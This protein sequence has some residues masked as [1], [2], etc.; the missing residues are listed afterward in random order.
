YDFRRLYAGVAD[1]LGL[2]GPYEGWRRYNTSQG[3]YRV[4]YDVG[5]PLLKTQEWNYLTDNARV[6]QPDGTSLF[7]HEAIRD[8]WLWFRPEAGPGFGG[9]RRKLGNTYITQRMG[10]GEVTTHVSGGNGD[11]DIIGNGRVPCLNLRDCGLTMD[12]FDSG[13]FEIN[14]PYVITMDPRCTSCGPYMFDVKGTQ[15]GG[16]LVAEWSPST[17][18]FSNL[19]GAAT[20]GVTTR[21]EVFDLLKSSVAMGVSAE[22]KVSHFWAFG[23]IDAGGFAAAELW[24]GERTSAMK[25]DGTPAEQFNLMKIGVADDRRQTGIADDPTK[26]GIADGDAWPAARFGA[27]L[28]VRG[29]VRNGKHVKDV[30]I[31]FANGDQLAPPETKLPDGRGPDGLL[32]VGGDSG[33]G[34][35][36]DIWTFDGAWRLAGRLPGVDGGLADAGGAA[37]ADSVWLFG[38]RQAGG[39]S[40]DIW[41]VDR[42]TGAAERIAPSVSPW[43]AAR[44]RPAVALGSGGAEM[45]VFGGTAHGAAL[46]DAWAYSFAAGTWRRIA[47][48]CSGSGCP[49]VTGGEKLAAGAAGR[50][51]AVVADPTGAAAGRMTWT[52]EMGTWASWLERVGLSLLRDCDLSPSQSR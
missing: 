32:L 15:V 10:L 41:R 45:I 7:P 43:P 46:T 9:L 25:I 14:L 29:D 22:G 30:A 1:P 49:V 11:F 36:D 39:P 31:A 40:A 2:A 28:V 12:I 23:G 42:R 35:L 51:I 3:P 21:E 4:W 5:D 13:P 33:A 38:G 26:I 52:L 17:G 48:P 34:L 18:L 24:F 16:M 20:K 47:A 19:V 6:R 8:A 27:A 44:V 50:Q 37:D